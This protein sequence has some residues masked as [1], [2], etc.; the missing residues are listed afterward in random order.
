VLVNVSTSAKILLVACSL[1]WQSCSWTNSFFNAS[2]KLSEK[3]AAQILNSR[4]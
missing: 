3:V 1:L 4:L 2:K